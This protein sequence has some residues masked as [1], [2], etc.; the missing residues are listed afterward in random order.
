VAASVRDTG[1]RNVQEPARRKFHTL[2]EE[3]LPDFARKRG[4]PRLDDLNRHAGTEFRITWPDS[5]PTARKNIERPLAFCRF[6]MDREWCANP[7]S[8]PKVRVAARRKDPFTAQE[9]DRILQATHLRGDGHGRTGRPNAGELRMRNAVLV[10]GPEFAPFRA[11]HAENFTR[12]G[13]RARNYYGKSST[14]RSR[15]LLFQR[16]TPD[17]TRDCNSAGV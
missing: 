4:Y 7:A 14:E 16:W 10:S 17:C 6:A 8:K 9:F 11:L 13:S 2:I 3:R 1:A 5:P 15:C 12:L